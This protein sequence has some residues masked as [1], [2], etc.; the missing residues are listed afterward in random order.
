MRFVSVLIYRCIDV[1]RTFYLFEFCW[2]LDL[3]LRALVLGGRDAGGEPASKQLAAATTQQCFVGLL[4]ELGE[5]F[6][7]GLLDVS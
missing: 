6:C 4:A 3:A 2:C 5:Y 1:C 7:L